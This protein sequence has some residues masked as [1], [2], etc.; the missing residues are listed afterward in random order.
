MKEL[1]VI[2]DRE[3]SRKQQITDCVLTN[4]ETFRTEASKAYCDF[5]P[6]ER[7]LLNGIKTDDIAG[8]NV[9]AAWHDQLKPLYHILHS[10]LSDK[11]FRESIVKNL[12]LD[13]EETQSR[14]DRLITDRKSEIL[15]NFIFDIYPIVNNK[16]KDIYKKQRERVKNLLSQPESEIE[17]IRDHQINY[18]LYKG[19][20]SQ[21]HI[22]VVDPYTS[23][24]KRIKARKCIH[25]E[26]KK[27]LAYENNRLSYITER[28]RELSAMNGGLLV[29]FLDK[30]WDLIVVLDLRNRY[31]KEIT[32]LSP[33]DKK[34]A[35]KRLAI[36]D[37]KTHEFKKEQ[38][39]KIAISSDQVSL[40]TTR[41]I[42]KDIDALLLRIF[43]L[44]TIQKNQLLLCTKEYR[45]LTQEQ[46]AILQTQNNRYT[47][48][49]KKH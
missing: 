9:L 2:D 17:Q 10:S 20:A 13:K 6:N 14:I 28:L 47:A 30:K 1:P 39:E 31:E 21:N 44:T 41:T 7:A 19:A 40:E 46:S 23:L 4:V 48:I 49:S 36:F 11:T 38:I 3:Q 42:T 27:T 37:A 43:D 12:V 15:H 26:R 16:R 33:N 5:T 45:E 34:D 32:K 35:I 25:T 8:Y 24:F 29:S 18:I 22:T